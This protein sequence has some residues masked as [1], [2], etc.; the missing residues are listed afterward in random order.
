MIGTMMNTYGREAQEYW[1]KNLPSRYQALEDPET[2]FSG[3][4]EEIA[5]QVE[6]ATEKL[7]GTDSADESYLE[8]VARLNSARITAEELVKQDLMFLPP[9][10][11]ALMSPT[12]L[13]EEWDAVRPMDEAIIDWVETFWMAETM[14]LADELEET[15]NRW[16]LPV[17]FL[18]EML[19][20]ELPR[21]VWNDRE[22]LVAAAADQRFEAWMK[23]GAD[24]SNP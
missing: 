11:S 24:L 13:R 4:G 7:Q 5:Q 21:K 8:K 15:A 18:Q 2:F 22:D 19:Q 12:E 9:E 23:A 17:S 1:L 14:P 20:A 3:L 16:M 10:T 6:Q